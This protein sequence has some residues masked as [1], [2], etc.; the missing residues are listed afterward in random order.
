MIVHVLMLTKPGW[1]GRGIGVGERTNQKG[2]NG[3]DENPEYRIPLRMVPFESRAAQL[4]S[5]HC[6]ELARK[7]ETGLVPAEASL[8]EPVGSASRTD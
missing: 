6:R 5:E 3:A 7:S 1:L 2:R 8:Y 4:I